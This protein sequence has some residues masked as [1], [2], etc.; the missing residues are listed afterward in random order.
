MDGS[1]RTS[2][3]KSVRPLERARHSGN[4]GNYRESSPPFSINTGTLR[5]PQHPT[6]AGDPDGRSHH[7][8]PGHGALHELVPSPGTDIKLAFV[9]HG[10]RGFPDTCGRETYASPSHATPVGGVHPPSAPHST[11]PGHGY[12]TTVPPVPC[13]ISGGHPSGSTAPGA[14]GLT[15]NMVKG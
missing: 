4:R 9:T 1:G 5:P 8:Q 13:G 12:C 15:Y 2:T 7:P 10:P 3:A 11:T 14:T 6:G